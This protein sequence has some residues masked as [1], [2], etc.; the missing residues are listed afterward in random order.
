[1]LFTIGFLIR[2]DCVP[3]VFSRRHLVL[4]MFISDACGDLAAFPVRCVEGTAGKFHLRRCPPFPFAGVF[5]KIDIADLVSYQL[6]AVEGIYCSYDSTGGRFLERL[7][8]GA[9]RPTVPPPLLIQYQLQL[10]VDPALARPTGE[11]APHLFALSPTFAVLHAGNAR[12][13]QRRQAHDDGPNDYQHTVTI[14][15]AVVFTHFWPCFGCFGVRV[16][17]SF[18]KPNLMSHC[19]HYWHVPLSEPMFQ[20]CCWAAKSW[21]W[22]RVSAL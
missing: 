20:P 1:M 16:I 12:S 18:A 19:G 7:P 8:V 13:A 5:R 11:P 10:G 17:R 15:I 22:G 2:S 4:L 3:P 9:L 6:P 21:S 14:W